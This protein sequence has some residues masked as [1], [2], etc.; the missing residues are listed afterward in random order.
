MGGRT[1][2]F[3]LDL[4]SVKY[5]PP[6]FKVSFL[7]LVISIQSE[8]SE[9][10]SVTPFSLLAKNSDILKSANDLVV[11]TSAKIKYSDLEPT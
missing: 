2:F 5:H 11:K 10:S 6:I 8:W 4:S 3:L 9:S 7:V 1:H